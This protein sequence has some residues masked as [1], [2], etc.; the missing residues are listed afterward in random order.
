MVINM[1]CV[2]CVNSTCNPSRIFDKYGVC[3]VCNEYKSRF[4]QKVLKDELC[5]LKTMIKKEQGIDCLA[6][7][8]GGKD[9]IAMLQNICDMGFHPLAFTFDIGYNEITSKQRAAI[10][11]A[12]EILGIN[13]EY[14]NARQ[15]L[16]EAD[17]KSF[18]LTAKLYD[19]QLDHMDS[20][21]IRRMFEEERYCN[22]PRSQD[23]RP[24]IRPCRLCRRPVIRGYYAEAVKRN[25]SVI[26]LGINEWCGIHNSNYSAIRKLEPIPGKAVYIVHLPFLLQRRIGDLHEILRRLEWTTEND[27][28]PNTGASACMLARIA[29]SKVVS[30]LGFNPDETRLAREVTVGFLTREQAL[31]VLIRPIIPCAISM[32]DVLVDLL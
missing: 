9:S 3:N 19:S 7:V 24:F 31:S 12:T 6:A 22:S 29:E 2:K 32:Q 4:N 18:Y 26:F 15:Y 21:E 14:I 16:N 13:H 5:F 11:K 27:I 30:K 17:R 25:I 23:I 10:R 1:R 20:G 28:Q 8:S